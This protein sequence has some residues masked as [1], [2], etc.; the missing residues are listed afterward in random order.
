MKINDATVHI[1]QQQP[2]QFRR[3]EDGKEPYAHVTDQKLTSAPDQTKCSIYINKEKI[4][5]IEQGIGSDFPKIFDY[6]AG[7]KISTQK[8]S[9]TGKEEKVYERYD[10]NGKTQVTTQKQSFFDKMA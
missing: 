6:D 4:V 2:G 3:P 8:I 9:T 7:L 1:R 10:Q 5:T